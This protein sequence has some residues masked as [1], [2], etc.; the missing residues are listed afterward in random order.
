MFAAFVGVFEWTKAD[1]EKRVI[2]AIVI[3]AKPKNG[4][5]I[6]LKRAKE[7]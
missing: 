6:K 1:P 5:N 4:L 7:W 3:T 2:P